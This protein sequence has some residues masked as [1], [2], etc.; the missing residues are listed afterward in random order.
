MYELGT[1]GKA[2]DDA[3]NISLN[4]VRLRV[5]PVSYTHLPEKIDFAVNT[6][7]PDG[8]IL[9]IGTEKG[10]FIQKNGQLLQVLTDRNMLA[11]CNRIM[12]LCLNEDKSALWLATRCV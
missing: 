10:L 7:L 1:T 3:L 11:A 5:N 8:D 4:L 9:Y 2:L 6:L 12:D